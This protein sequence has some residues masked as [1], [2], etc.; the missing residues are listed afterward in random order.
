[1]EITPD[2]KDW[3]WVLHRPCR[4]C[5]LDTRTLRRESIPGL[6]R[7][8]AAAW[9][10]VLEERSDVRDR[11]SPGV[12]SPLE[13]GCHVRDV[14]RLYHERLRLMLVEDDPLYANWD[15]DATAV[16]ERYGEQ[17]PVRVAGELRDAAAV[18]AD[19]FATVTG[20]EWQ[21]T[22][23]RSDGARFTVETFA[24]YFVHDPIHHLYDATGRRYDAGG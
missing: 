20:D 9:V 14:C 11:P 21:R 8:T 6:L 5:G 12:W 18:L 17:D 1:V 15:Q 7:D 16:A 3:T 23:N 19:R 2:T 13:Y 10:A 24:R 22:G 4:E